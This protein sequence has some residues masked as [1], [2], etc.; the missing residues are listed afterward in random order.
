[1][2]QSIDEVPG[3][4]RVEVFECQAFE[5]GRSRREVESRFEEV[6]SE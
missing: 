1:M 5:G 6:G 3:R 2:L 4:R